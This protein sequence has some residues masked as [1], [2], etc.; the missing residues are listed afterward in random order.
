MAIEIAPTGCAQA[1]ARDAS[2]INAKISPGREASEAW[3][4]SRV[5]VFLAPMRSAIQAWVAGGIM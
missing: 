1:I 2:S 5:M 3:L 4:A